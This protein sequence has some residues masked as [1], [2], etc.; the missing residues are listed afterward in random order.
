[1][2]NKEKTKAK[3]CSEDAKR[4]PKLKPGE[5]CST[6]SGMRKEKVCAFHCTLCNIPRLPLGKDRK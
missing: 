3:V 5:P 4:Y 2:L 1:M 6:Y